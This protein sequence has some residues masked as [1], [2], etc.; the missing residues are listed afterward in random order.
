M[1][2][3]TSALEPF[4]N[5]APRSRDELRYNEV[6]MI[7]ACRCRIFHSFYI[8]T[9]TKLTVLFAIILSVGI[10]RTSAAAGDALYF[11][12][13][14]T[15][16][17]PF[18]PSSVLIQSP[19]FISVPAGAVLSVYLMRGDTV[20]SISKL[21]FQQGYENTA[22]IPA[23]PV[24][25]FVPLGTSTGAGQPLPVASLVPGEADLTRVAMEPS[26]YRVLWMLSAGVIGTPGRAIVTGAPVS[27]VDLILIGVS[28]ASSV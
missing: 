11:S 16:A 21:S 14:P 26:R 8:L 12:F 9:M 10:L 25:S 19:S 27:F 7:K 22:L 20:V 28:A 15:S 17:L 5:E 23:V 2:N 24:A 13:Q 18:A 1:L 3:S 4:K 6:S